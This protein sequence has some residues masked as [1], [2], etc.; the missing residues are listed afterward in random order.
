MPNP[1]SR[2]R[3]M[4]VAAKANG[5]TGDFKDRLVVVGEGID[6]ACLVQCLRK[7]LCCHA[8]TILLVEGSERQEARGEEEGGRAQALRVPSAVLARRL[9]LPHA[10][11]AAAAASDVFCCEETPANDCHIM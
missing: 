3:A 6:I 8:V 1:C 5:I 11:A 4:E 9:L 7:K 2:S 10:A